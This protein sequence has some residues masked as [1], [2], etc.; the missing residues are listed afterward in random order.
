M[1]HRS[2]LL[3]VFFALL[4]A[5]TGCDPDDDPPANDRD[6]DG[7]VDGDDCNP[8]D[9]NIY[10]GAPDNYGDGVDVDCDGVDGVDRDQD[11]FPGNAPPSDPKYD[12]DD[13]DETIHP[14]AEEIC[15]GVDNDCDGA[16][17]DDEEDDDGD[18]FAECDGD[19]D[20]ERSSAHPDASESCNGL[21]D[22]CDGELGD[23]EVDE[24]G[25]GYMICDGDCDDTD[26]TFNPGADEGCDGIDNDCD[27]E[28]SWD[29]LDDDGD[30][31]MACEGDCDDNDAEIYPGAMERCN[32]ED[33]DCDGELGAIEV[34]EDGDG[35]LACD[36]GSNDVDCDDTDAAIYPGAPELCNGLDD[37]CDG[38]AAGDETDDD[39]DGYAECDGDCDDVDGGVH[40][41]AYEAADG[42]DND[43]DGTVDED[44]C[45][46]EFDGTDDLALVPASDTPVLD[47][48]LT[49][50]A[51]VRVDANAPVWHSLI[52]GRWG[53]STDATCGVRLFHD[54]ASG[55]FG[56][57]V[58]PDGSADESIIGSTP[59]TLGAW[60]HVAG[61]YNGVRL[62][63]Y[64]DGNL[65]GDVLYSDGVLDNGL[66]L[67]IGDYNPS[68]IQGTYDFQLTGSVAAVRVATDALYA[69]PTLT[70]A[71]PF[72]PDPAAALVL[73]LDEGADQWL[74]DALTNLPVGTRGLTD[75]ADADDPSW[76]CGPEF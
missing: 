14:E 17:L 46:L 57:A 41:Y 30:G 20:D 60:H 24:D 50:E 37:D 43:C 6:G 55:A 76:V 11:G 38:Q 32:G 53:N 13:G 21:D 36:G 48:S 75:T 29:E 35:Y 2:M 25:D 73:Y 16:A 69:G 61:V 47:G 3:C 72:T 52:A 64:L 4:L 34:D 58:S 10:P 7:V 33:D 65:D 70:P 62:A 12:C 68:W 27:G 1:F 5:T 15:D 71:L 51:W 39:G 49:L 42:V 66:G 74:Y 45:Q 44:P 54:T 56:F 22:N 8:D 63:L 67:T 18:G 40:P 59:A 31:L 26:D 19:C 28:P 9:P 23:E